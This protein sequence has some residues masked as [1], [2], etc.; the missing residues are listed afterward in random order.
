MDEE[1]LKLLATCLDCGGTK[2]TVNIYGEP[3]LCRTCTP[4]P[5]LDD[6]DD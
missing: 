3:D 1:E 4:V 5:R 6:Q 2:A